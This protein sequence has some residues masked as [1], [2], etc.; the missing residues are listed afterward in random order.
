MLT[1]PYRMG[2]RQLEVLAYKSSA[3]GRWSTWTEYHAT[4]ITVQPR[5]SLKYDQD[6]GAAR[7]AIKDTVDSCMITN[8]ILASV[9]VDPQLDTPLKPAQ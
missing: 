2:R 6:M 7:E 1:F 5:L 8:S 4:R 3:Q 9:Q